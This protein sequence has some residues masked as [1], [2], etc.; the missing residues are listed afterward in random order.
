[1]FGGAHHVRTSELGGDG[2]LILVEVNADDARCAGNLR[3]L[4]DGKA[5]RAEAEDCHGGPRLHFA[6]VPDSAKTGA[7]AA[8]EEARLV[9]GHARVNFRRADFSDDGVLGEGGASHEVEDGFAVQGVESRGAIRH[10]PGTLRAT[11]GGA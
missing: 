6:R 1:M 7:D 11:D 5:H 3:R 9:E 2:E 4:D 10:V 8:A